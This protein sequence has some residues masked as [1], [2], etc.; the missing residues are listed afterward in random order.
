MKATLSA[1]ATPEASDGSAELYFRQGNKQG[2]LQFLPHQEIR[3]KFEGVRYS[4]I[5]KCY[6]E[7]RAEMRKVLSDKKYHKYVTNGFFLPISELQAV[8]EL[9]RKII[10][11]HLD[12]GYKGS[13]LNTKGVWKT[14]SSV[15]ESNS[16]HLN[17][18]A[19]FSLTL[20]QELLQ[21]ANFC[22]MWIDKLQP[23][24][25]RPST[26]LS[27]DLPQDFFQSLKYFN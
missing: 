17:V 23:F 21:Y 19:T 5:V 10:Y 15:Q 6:N 8:V 11:I 18:N 25:P 12:K 20:I 26:F 4:E 14:L 2:N 16:I 9:Y 13:S 3:G 1:A 7:K 22:R 24:F 27:R